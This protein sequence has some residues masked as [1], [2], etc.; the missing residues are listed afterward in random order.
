MG[1]SL[2][3]GM[4][5]LLQGI[6]KWLEFWTRGLHSSS[7]REGKEAGLMLMGCHPP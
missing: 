1:P 7:E 5:W 2:Y 4:W 3:D 6:E